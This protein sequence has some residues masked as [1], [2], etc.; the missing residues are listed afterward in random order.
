M[1]DENKTKGQLINELIELHQHIAELETSETE[2][3]RVEE[4]LRKTN[5]QRAIELK[6]ANE[7]LQKE[8]TERKR[9]EKISNEHPI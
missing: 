3:K 7:Q 8:I 2:R 1:K 9:M 4:E 5:A 6:M